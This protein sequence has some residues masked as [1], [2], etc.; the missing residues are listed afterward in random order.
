MDVGT[1]YE[2][3]DHVYHNK[4]LLLT[5]PDDAAAGAMGYLMVSMSVIGSG[6]EAAVG[7]G[8]C[9]EIK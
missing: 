2:E 6:D 9:D 8:S 3:D 4:W 5:S 1:V 7:L